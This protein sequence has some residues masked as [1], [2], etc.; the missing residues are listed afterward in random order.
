MIKGG[1][2][3]VLYYQTGDEGWVYD[4]IVKAREWNQAYQ[5]KGKLIIQPPA[6][7]DEQRQK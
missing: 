6:S 5:G 7:L 1:A 3:V 4:W 2:Q